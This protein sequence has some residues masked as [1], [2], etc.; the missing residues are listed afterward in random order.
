MA[1]N[2]ILNAMSGGDTMA[3]EEIGG[4]KFE[5]V[6]VNLGAYG[7]NDGPVSDTNRLPAK[8]GNIIASETSFT[9]PSDTTTYAAG[10][11]VNNS[12]SAPTVLTF[13]NIA[14]ASG[15]GGVIESATMSLSTRATLA[16]VFEL[17]LFDT[18]VTMTND[19]TAWGI[20]DA[21]LNTAI[22]CINFSVRVDGDASSNCIYQA[23]NIGIA[24]KCT[25]TSLFGVLVARNAYVPGN[26]E[27]FT[28][29]LKCL[30]E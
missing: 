2:I 13:T 12:T 7:V 11:A 9:R 27:V 21:N 1:H 16:G 20:S 29:R 3:A 26:A 5:N 8:V 25:T 6:K 23:T 19:N 28:I 24:Y 4:I 15:L 17:W 18:T 10:D 30:G 22:G 14:R